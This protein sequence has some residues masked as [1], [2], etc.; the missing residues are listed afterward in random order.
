MD[1][2]LLTDRKRDQP[3]T[4][5]ALRGLVVL[6]GALAV[7][8]LMNLWGRPAPLYPIPLVDPA[9]LDTATNRRSY[10]DLVRAKEDLSDFDCYACHERGKPPPLRFDE[11]QNLLIPREHSDI[12]MGHGE[13][14]RNNNCFNCHNETNLEL[15]Q[16]RDGRVLKFQDS[17]QLCGSCHGPTYE[18][19][20]AGAH[21]R[22]S[23]YWDRELGPIKRQDCVNC[24]NPHSPTFQGR[25]PAP[26]PHFLHEQVQA[27]A[28]PATGH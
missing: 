22:I 15:L 1:D 19:W 25:K 26:G 6:F 11:H 7:A 4:I 27:S 2:R 14:G 13:H 18:D 16:T 24:H 21:G 28:D 8:F 17:P 20:E 3:K 12:V 23:G 10:A 5:L 9:F